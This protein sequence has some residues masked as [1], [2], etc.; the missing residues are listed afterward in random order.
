[1]KTKAVLTFLYALLVLIGGIT[2]YAKASSLPSLLMGVAFALLLAISAY[3]QYQK[4][5][6]AHLSAVI[7]TVVLAVFF[8]WRFIQTLS[9]LPAGVMVIISAL[10]LIPLIAIPNESKA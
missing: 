8:L 2:G 10:V 7:L 6:L 4:S 5:V 3:G 1:M 9:F